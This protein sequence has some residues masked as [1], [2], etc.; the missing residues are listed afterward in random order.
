MALVVSSDIPSDEEIYRWIGEPVEML[1]IPNSVFITNNHNYPVLSKGHQRMVMLFLQNTK[2]HI[3][4]K[5]SS[6]FDNRIKL[7]A[8]Y[9]RHLAKLSYE[10]DPMLGYDDYLEIPLQPLYDNLDTFTYEIF[11]RDPVKYILYQKAIQAALIDKVAEDDIETVTIRL[12]IVG[13]GRGPLIRAAFNASLNSGRKIKLYVVEKNPNAIV[14]LYALIDEL[15]P[16][17]DITLI[18]TDMRTLVLDEK[19]DIIVSELL[20]SFGDN[21]LSPECL[22]GAQKHLK[23]DGISIPCNSISYVNPTMSSKI[24]NGIRRMANNVHSDCQDAMFLIPMEVNYVIYLKNVYHIDQPQKLFKFEHPHSDE[25]P[26]NTRMKTLQ[27]TAKLDCVLHGFSAYFSAQL[28][29]DI[30]ISILP[31]THT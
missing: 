14:T 1:V 3:A 28:Y 31:E 25:K 2:C 11:E 16:D 19:V 7:Y 4:I 30:E 27:F 20:G 24:Y 23:E 29:K 6:K 15:W 8:E 17:K 22:D 21:E 10:Y 5:P 18:S 9:I 13:A 26:D 12:L